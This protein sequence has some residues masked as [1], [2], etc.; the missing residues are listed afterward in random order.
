MN[1]EEDSGRREGTGTGTEYILAPREIVVAVVGAVKANRVVGVDHNDEVH[2]AGEGEKEGEREGRRKSKLAEVD[3]TSLQSK[4]QPALIM[5]KSNL[6]EG[7]G[8]VRD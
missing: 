6:K 8:R 2:E 3:E 5:I 1:K 7:R 4:P